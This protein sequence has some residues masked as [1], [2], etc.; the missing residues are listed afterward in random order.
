MVDFPLAG[1]QISKSFVM[2][3]NLGLIQMNVLK[4]MMGTLVK[5]V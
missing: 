2:A 4:Q 1:G 3:Y 5:H